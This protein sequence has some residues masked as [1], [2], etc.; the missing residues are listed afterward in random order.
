MVYNS[1]AKVYDLPAICFVIKSYT[2]RERRPF[3]VYD[4]TAIDNIFRPAAKLLCRESVK[5]VQRSSLRL[6]VFVTKS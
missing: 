3:L 1:S 2:P 4:L 6:A 5:P